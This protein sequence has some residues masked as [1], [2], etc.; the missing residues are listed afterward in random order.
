MKEFIISVIKLHTSISNW[1]LQMSKDCCFRNLPLPNNWNKL[2]K[3]R[4]SSF[5]ILEIWVALFFVFLFFSSVLITNR[6]STAFHKPIQLPVHI[7]VFNSQTIG[8]TEF[9]FTWN[10]RI[11][12]ILGTESFIFF[13]L[14]LKM[15]MISL[16]ARKTNYWIR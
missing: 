4:K 15:K 12:M 13:F 2:K 9:Q 8:C 6:K 14:C 10:K 3:K 7:Q 1:L 11:H 16:E 5:A